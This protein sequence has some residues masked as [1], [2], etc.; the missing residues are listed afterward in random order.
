MSPTIINTCIFFTLQFGPQRA[1]IAVVSSV[2]SYIYIA[3]LHSYISSQQAS[4]YCYSTSS[5]K[6]NNGGSNNLYFYMYALHLYLTFLNIKKGSD[7]YIFFT[8]SPSLTG[9]SVIYLAVV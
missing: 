2:Y 5:N 7:F 9:F 3:Y 1:F 6:E 8:I 4:T